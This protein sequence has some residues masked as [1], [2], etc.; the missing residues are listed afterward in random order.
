[1]LLRWTRKILVLA[2]AAFGVQYLRMIT[3]IVFAELR[4]EPPARPAGRPVHLDPV[5]VDTGP[6]LVRHTTAPRPRRLVITTLERHGA[7]S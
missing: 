4:P 7:L 1:M 3:R 5:L 6:V 2:L